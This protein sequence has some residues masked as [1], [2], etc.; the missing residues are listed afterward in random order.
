MYFRQ[1]DRSY[2]RYMHYDLDLDQFTE[3]IRI[4]SFQLHNGIS[5]NKKNGQLLFTNNTMP[6]A[7]IKKLEHPFLPK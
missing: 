3:L 5:L 4:P 7:D 2:R 6:Q 1:Y